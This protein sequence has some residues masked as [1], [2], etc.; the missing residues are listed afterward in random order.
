MRP[1]S[2]PK[3]SLRRTYNG[4]ETVGGAGGVGDDVVFGGVVFGVVEL[5][6]FA[7]E[8]GMLLLP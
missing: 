7:L 5:E 6:Q 2:I 4:G 3:P 1:S 8:V